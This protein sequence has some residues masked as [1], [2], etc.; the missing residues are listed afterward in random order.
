MCA[1]LISFSHSVFFF[2]C[3][4]LGVEPWAMHI[5]D[6][7]SAPE[8]Q[9]LACSFSQTLFMSMCLIYLGFFFLVVLSVSSA[10]KK[11]F[12]TLGLK[13]LQSHI[14]YQKFP[15]FVFLCSSSQTLVLV[16]WHCFLFLSRFRETFNLLCQS[17]GKMQLELCLVLQSI[18]RKL[19]FTL[20]IR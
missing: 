19:T 6:K 14:S 17:S 12:P 5:L 16:H 18:W 7:C 10:I 20:L 15:S 3:A 1:V 11:Y 9:A 8:F 2:L 4:V 13:Y